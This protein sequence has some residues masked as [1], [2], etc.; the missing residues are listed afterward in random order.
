MEIRRKGY[1]YGW[2]RSSQTKGFS[3]PDSGLEAIE[4]ARLFLP[5]PSEDLVPL[6]P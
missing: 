3:L 2:P 1:E 4:C 6:G 5:L